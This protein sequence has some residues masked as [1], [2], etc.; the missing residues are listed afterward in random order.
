MDY[1]RDMLSNQQIGDLR[2]RFLSQLKLD[3]QDENEIGLYLS[4]GIDS[5]AVLLGLLALNKEVTAYTFSLP[6]KLSTD[7]R[8]AQK[9]A[10][11]FNCKF[12]GV[13]LWQNVNLS[14][15]YKLMKTFQC[16][17]KTDIECLY[18][19][20]A[21][22]PHVKERVVL[23]GYES[24]DHFLLNRQAMTHY[25]KTLE[26]NQAYR[27][28]IFQNYSTLQFEKLKEI[29]LS[30]G[31]SIQSPYCSKPIY[32]FFYD[33]TWNDLNKPKRKYPLIQ[34]FDQM[35]LIGD[36]LYHSNLQ[37]GDSGLR[38]HFAVLLNSSINKNNRSRVMDLYRD[39][40]N[41]IRDG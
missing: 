7:F 11:K 20:L 25:K 9:V 27:R 3:C 26:L 31:K 38:E 33:K 12:V 39:L 35:S 17:K 6:G 32:D 15:V 22:M 40:F 30:H 1:T 34:M 8:T 13:E 24:D 14:I 36:L 10:E 16:R 41:E 23:T 5:C 18:P 28:S 19:F 21:T 29:G 4:G 37:M 2:D